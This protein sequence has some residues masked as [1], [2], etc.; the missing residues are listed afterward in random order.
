MSIHILDDYYLGITAIITF[1]YQLIICLIAFTLQAETVTD[2]GGGT[3]AALLAILT[4]IF[5]QSYSTRQII[6]TLFQIIW[7]LRLGFFCLYRMT[8][9][10]HGD[11]RFD[12]IRQ[13]FSKLLAFF[14]L[15]MIWIW[16]INLP[17]TFLNSPKINDS[18]EGLDQN[19]G[20]VTDI[21]G[22]ILFI[23]GFLMETV[24]DVQKL[25]FRTRRTSSKEFIKTGL[26]AWSRH[27]NYFGEITLWIGMFLLC[28]QANLRDKTTIVSI[29]SPIF[30][31]LILLFLSGMPLNERPA[32]IKQY[33][34]GNWSEYSRRLSRT[35]CLIPFPPSLYEPL[36]QFIKST[37]FLEFPMYRFDPDSNSQVKAE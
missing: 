30:T 21:L 7:G 5:S 16:T 12:E 9:T 2:L 8:R 24:A 17:L 28:L 31:I 3:N 22:V 11:S 20:S 33:K 18:S 13:H 27:P 19:F 35:S 29:L 15:Q 26:W 6:A 37:L 25:I 23:V 32:H 1:L 36:P 10:G 34:A 14:I 4:L